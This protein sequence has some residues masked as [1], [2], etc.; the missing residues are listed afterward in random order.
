[1]R[2]LLRIVFLLY[3]VFMHETEVWQSDLCYNV[4]Q[5]S[6]GCM[7]WLKSLVSK[8][9]CMIKERGECICL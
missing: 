5:V 3:Y 4:W 2:V 6:A 7:K 1:M 9:N 8:V